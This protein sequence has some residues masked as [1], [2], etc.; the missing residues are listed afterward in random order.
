MADSHLADPHEEDEAAGE[1]D[2]RGGRSQERGEGG[3][4][5]RVC[6]VREE[7]EEE[8]DA[9]VA[10]GDVL[11]LED[12]YRDAAPTRTGGLKGRISRVTRGR[13]G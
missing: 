1:A 8:V 5:R 9:E 12:V 4:E 6:D 2:G 13:C 3:G 10:S 7:E 11:E